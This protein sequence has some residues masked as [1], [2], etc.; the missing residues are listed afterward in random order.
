MNDSVKAK[1][2][3]A[4]I[5]TVF[6]TLGFFILGQIPV[7]LLIANS[8]QTSILYNEG[9]S[10]QVSYSVYFIMLNIPFVTG[11][12]GLLISNYIFHHSRII[13]LFN[14][15]HSFRWN[16]WLKGII[17]S[18]FII[19]I[20]DLINYVM[21]PV[22]FQWQFNAEQFFPFLGVAFLMFPIQTGF[23][24][25]FF[26]GYLFKQVGLRSRNIIFAWILTS[27][28]FGLAHS[29]NLEVS[30]FGL[31]KM[32][33]IYILLGLGLGFVTIVS[34]GIEIAM[35]FHLVNNLYV[36]LV[37]TFPGSSLN[38]PA[39][40]MTPSPD[41]NYMVVESIIGISIFVT[42]IVFLLPNKNW[43]QLFSFENR[44][45]EK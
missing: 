2:S 45:I 9:I 16:Y 21:H 33:F 15:F 18:A 4:F 19:I 40:F 5:A 35:G 8:G 38:T 20:S 23:E 29:F 1:N 41:P 22:D 11:L 12:F 39:L 10:Q 37:K 30:E 34:Q 44:F 36:A 14:G 32:L 26:R 13:S 24:E 6:I 43:K 17:V 3:I 28:L 42:I 27:V 31:A 7:S 25:L